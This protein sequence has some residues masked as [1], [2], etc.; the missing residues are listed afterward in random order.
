MNDHFRYLSPLALWAQGLMVIIMS[1]QTKSEKIS[2][3]KGLNLY[4]LFLGE[5]IWQIVRHLQQGI[6]HRNQ[7]Q[8]VKSFE[9]LMFKPPT[10]QARRFSRRLGGGVKNFHYPPQK[11]NEEIPIGSSLRL[12]QLGVSAREGILMSAYTKKYTK[13]DT[14]KKFFAW[15][16]GRLLRTICKKFGDNWTTGTGNMD[17]FGFPTHSLLE[18]KMR[19]N[20]FSVHKSLTF[21]ENIMIF[22]GGLNKIPSHQ[23]HEKFSDLKMVWRELPIKDLWCV[24]KEKILLPPIMSCTEKQFDRI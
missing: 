17:W 8:V 18:N 13:G 19:K 15:Y 5:A 24:S 3:Q 10:T 21:G 20:V 2:Q 1:P 11:R 23:L 12:V 4:G 6:V 22:P 9:A 7:H 14:I 16:L